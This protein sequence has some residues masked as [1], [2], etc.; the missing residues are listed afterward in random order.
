MVI[1]FQFTL[2]DIRSFG[3]FKVL[4]S[5]QWTGPNFDKEFVRGNGKMYENSRNR[6]PTRLGNINIWENYLCPTTKGIKI[7][8]RLVIPELDNLQI[9]N[10]F[11]HYFYDGKVLSKFQCCFDTDNRRRQYDYH[12]LELIIERILDLKVSVRNKAFKYTEHKFSQ[13]EKGLQELHLISTTNIKAINDKHKAC[14]KTC[15]PQIFVSLNKNENFQ[16]P[17]DKIT[18]IPIE[19][20]SGSALYCWFQESSGRTFKSWL[21][22]NVGDFKDKKINTLK[23][24]IL[25]IHA[26]KECFSNVIQAIKNKKFSKSIT[27]ERSDS[28]QDFLHNKLKSI[29]LTYKKIDTIEENSDEIER[30]IKQAYEDA[31]PTMAGLEE[32]MLSLNFRSQIRINIIRN[33]QNEIDKIAELITTLREKYKKKHGHDYDFDL[34]PLNINLWRKVGASAAAEH[35]VNLAR[36][37][38]V[39][40]NSIFDV[41]KAIC[42]QF[43]KLI[44]HNGLVEHLYDKNKKRR[45]ERFPQ[46]L[47]YAIAESYCSAN[48]LDLNREINAGSGALDFKISSGKAKVNVEMKYSDNP[49]LIEGYT[50]QLAAYNAAEGVAVNHSIYLIL[51]VGT[52]GNGKIETLSN[53]VNEKAKNGEQHASLIIVDAVLKPS[54]SKL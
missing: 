38:R 44:E 8:R 47:F 52:R 1:I 28:L 5:P 24:G 12:E 16:F 27:P 9:T 2:T 37:K 45:S 13:L 17:S 51:K 6:I 34:D 39:T 3:N 25:R 50:K 20:D 54:A 31:Y 46:L 23:N 7:P 18:K 53:L 21:L 32:A 11:N 14:I 40:A 33:Q 35:P 42:Q 10:W 19:G 43:Q 26:E 15:M 22:R 41:V 36:Y 48:R 4:N 30:F 29:S 49:K